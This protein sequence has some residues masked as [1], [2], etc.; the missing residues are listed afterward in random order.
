MRSR[1][2][3]EK[4]SYKVVQAGTKEVLALNAVAAQNSLIIELL[5]DIRDL[6]TNK[7]V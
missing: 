6:F 2:E 7:E 5:L 3:I 4:L 1:E